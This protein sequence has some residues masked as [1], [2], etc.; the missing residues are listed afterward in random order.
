MFLRFHFDLH[1]DFLGV[2]LTVDEEKA[3][4]A[5]ISIM[6]DATSPFSYEMHPLHYNTDTFNATS[7]NNFDFSS[8]NRVPR[9]SLTNLKSCLRNSHKHSERF[10]DFKNSSEKVSHDDDLTLNQ[11]QAVKSPKK[12]VTFAD[13]EGGTLTS[14]KYVTEAS[15][16]PPRNLSSRNLLNDC[17]KDSTSPG[18]NAS[19]TNPTAKLC[20]Q[21]SQPAADYVTFKRKLD[22]RNV[23]LENVIV[24]GSTSIH[25][26]VKV[27]NIAYQKTVTVRITFNDWSSHTDIPCDYVNNAYENGI[28]DT[29]QFIIDAPP[30]FFEKRDLIQFCIC[31][32][33]KSQQF[34]DN[35]SG[36]NY[37]ISFCDKGRIKKT[38]PA[39]KH[40]SQP[41]PTTY[42][43][44]PRPED[45]SWPISEKSTP[46]Y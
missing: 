26:T 6:I 4:P 30:S 44:L 19:N 46:F 12:H 3:M 41:Y 13:A 16:E 43:E 2:A 21:F 33:C 1:H 5:D 37:C 9:L 17:L 34:W 27:K 15:H 42:S 39:R 40:L 11:E 35:N 29:F 31:Y 28:Y 32:E 38:P 22:E 24:N 10:C 25:G 7:N 14:V 45:P 18:S 20:L 23:S 36:R 8:F